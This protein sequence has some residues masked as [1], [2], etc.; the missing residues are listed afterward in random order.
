METSILRLTLEITNRRYWSDLKVEEW[1]TDLMNNQPNRHLIIFPCIIYHSY[2][3][4]CIVDLDVVEVYL[5]IWEWTWVLSSPRVECCHLLWW[6][7]LYDVLCHNM[8]TQPLC[9]QWR[10]TCTVYVHATIVCTCTIQEV[11]RV[12]NCGIIAD[13]ACTIYY[14]C[15]NGMPDRVVV[16]PL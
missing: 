4:L 10:G 15:I 3:S 1:W 12:V 16:S 14:L 6:C 7:E 5:Y 9:M 11:C 13:T 8:F 2:T